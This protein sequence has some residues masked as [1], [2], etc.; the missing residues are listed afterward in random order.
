MASAKPATVPVASRTAARGDRGDHPGRADGDDDVARA[1]AQARGRRRRC[2]RRRR[3]VTAPDGRRARPPSPGRATRGQ[4]RA[5]APKAQLEQ[6]AAVVA[7]LGR[8]V[9][10]AAGVAAVG[11]ERRQAVGAAASRQVSQSW[12]RQTAA[13]RAALSGSCSASQ[14]SLVTV[15]EATGTTPTASA[16]ACG[17]AQLVDQVGGGARPSG[18]RSTAAPGAPRAPRSSRQ[19]MPCCWPPTASAATSSSPPAVGDAVCERRPPRVGVAP[20]CRRG[21]RRAPRG[22][23]SPVSASRTTTLQDWVEESIPATSVTS[24]MRG[25]VRGRRQSR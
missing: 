25:F 10:G 19:T 9:A 12:G 20:R 11:G 13:V 8:P 18:C 3:Q 21:A 5:S 14:R 23:S 7:G 15:K 4:Q 2:R 17:A 6:V 24:V 1:G 16:Q 22:R